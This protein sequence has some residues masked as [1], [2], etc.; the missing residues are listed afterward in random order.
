MVDDVLYD[1]L[2][3]ETDE[4]H[5]I[6]TGAELGLLLPVELTALVNPP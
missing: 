4:I 1:M 2:E 3:R 6:T 5:D